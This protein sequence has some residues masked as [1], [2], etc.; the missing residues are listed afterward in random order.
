MINIVSIDVSVKI[1]IYVPQ[2]KVDII[3]AA[4]ELVKWLL[5]R[6]FTFFLRVILYLLHLEN[7]FTFYR[8]EL[9]ILLSFASLFNCLIVSR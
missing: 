8:Y 1:I 6:E 7:Y 9:Y 5:L 4:N 3:K 2:V